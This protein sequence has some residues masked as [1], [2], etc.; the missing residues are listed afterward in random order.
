M[1]MKAR[2]GSTQK[3]SCVEF[4]RRRIPIL[5]PGGWASARRHAAGKEGEGGQVGGGGG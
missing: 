5:Q 4:L 3:D 1:V 2:K